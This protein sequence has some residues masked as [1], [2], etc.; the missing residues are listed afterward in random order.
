MI[1]IVAWFGMITFLSGVI[2]YSFFAVVSFMEGEANIPNSSFRNGL[3]VAVVSC[4]VIAL[5]AGG[6][7]AFHYSM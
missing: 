4:F 5:I 6:V 1:N 3:L 2:G 7:V